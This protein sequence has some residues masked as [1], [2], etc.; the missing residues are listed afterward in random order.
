MSRLDALQKAANKKEFAVIIGVD[1]SFLT[2]TLYINKIESQYYQ[3]Q[4]PKRNGG[5]RTINAPTSELKEIQRRL[6]KL[7]LDCID[8]INTLKEIKPKLSHGFTR[9]RSI[10]TN[11]EKHTNQK[12]ILNLDLCDFFDSFNFGRVRGYFIKNKKFLLHTDISTVIAKIACLNDTLPQGSPCSPVITNLITH[13]LDIRLASLA[14]KESCIYSRYADD[15]TFSTRKKSFSS[16][17]VKVYKESTTI[18]N[19]LKR[20]IAR[21]GFSINDKKTR[22][23]FTDSRQEVTGLVVNKKVS[24]KSEYWRT[25]RAMC[26]NLFTTGQYT[27]HV[28]NE[29]Q[30]GTVSE[31]EGRLNFIDSVDKYN[32]LR[33][34]GAEEYKYQHKNHGLDYRK[35][36]NVREKLFSKFLYYQSFVANEQP[37]ILCE[38][39]TDNIY[40]K[41]AINI[42]FKD[43]PLLANEKKHTTP[44]KLLVNFYNYSK[45]SDYLLDL[46]GG[47]SYLKKFVERFKGNTKFYKNTLPKSP[48]ILLLDN[49][50][51]PNELLKLLVNKKSGFHNVPKT[52]DATRDAEFIH[53]ISNLYLVLTPRDKGEDTMMED[54][55]NTSTLG[56]L[57]DGRKFDP[58]KDADTTKTYGKNTF[59]IKVVKENKTNISFVG[60][61]EILNRINSVIK[62]HD[63]IYISQP[64]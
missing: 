54:F 26:H 14:K 1:A 11:A 40:L 39:K 53:I 46:N 29:I 2:R 5:E 50:S 62:Y 55:F 37:T 27:R 63:K 57:V 51:G 20:E 30:I 16:K 9:N 41:S 13:S 6:S 22:V 19:K 45:R 61:K 44:Y 7:L 28:P 35:K 49:D 59:S 23:Q 38:G 48:V 58:T 25:T 43:Y 15:L 52:T 56:T 18:G 32:H 64:T 31:L 8:E 47:G 12:H 3:F 24:I 36:L 34:K 10:I 33:P 4:I 60:F 21:S 42:L 17:I